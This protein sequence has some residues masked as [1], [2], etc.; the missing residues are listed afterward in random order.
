MRRPHRDNN[1]NFPRFWKIR[2]KLLYVTFM[3]MIQP[4]DVCG[5]KCVTNLGVDMARFTQF[6]LMIP[7]WAYYLQNH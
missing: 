5:G 6:H 1:Y 7:R 2:G 4:G 3:V